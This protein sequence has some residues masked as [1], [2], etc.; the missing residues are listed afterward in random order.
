MLYDLETHL[1][2]V[3]TDLNAAWPSWSLDSRFVYFEGANG[4]CRVRVRG[5]KLEC[6]A[7]L[8]DV[9]FAP[10]SVR[11]IGLTPDGSLLRTRD[12]GVMEIFALD[13]EAP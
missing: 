12:A 1:Q 4:W 3:L 11:W 7:S 10:T 5:R 9:N 6:L 13:W 8:K 2:T